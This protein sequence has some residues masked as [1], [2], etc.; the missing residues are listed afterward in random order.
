MLYLLA[1][2]PVGML[3]FTVAVAMFAS[4]LYLI[5]APVIAPFDTIG[6]GFWEPTPGTR[7]SR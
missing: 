6:L 1:R 3:T 5:A 4:A 2:F 7:A